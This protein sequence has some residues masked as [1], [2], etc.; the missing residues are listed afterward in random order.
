[1]KKESAKKLGKEI[2]EFGQKMTGKSGIDHI[3]KN[4]KS[5]Y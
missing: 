4:K 2:G 3:V 1:M 5:M